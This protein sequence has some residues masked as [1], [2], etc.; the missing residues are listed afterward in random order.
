MLTAPPTPPRPLPV[1]PAVPLK[2][3]LI[4]KRYSGKSTVAAK[5]AERFGLVVLSV[6]EIMEEVVG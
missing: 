1:L 3:A 5:I 6:D 2:M 4:G